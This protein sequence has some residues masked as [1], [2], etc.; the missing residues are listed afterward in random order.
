[1]PDTRQQHACFLLVFSCEKKTESEMIYT[2]RDPLPAI[3]VFSLNRCS[4]G[5]KS[6]TELVIPPRLDIAGYCKNQ[7]QVAAAIS[8]LSVRCMYITE[9]LH[10]TYCLRS[11]IVEY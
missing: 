8:F 7:N 10:V 5:S 6:D 4:R 1:M 3:L 2:F 11:S 9:N